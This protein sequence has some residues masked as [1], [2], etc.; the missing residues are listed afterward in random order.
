MPSSGN[1]DEQERVDYFGVNHDPLEV[2]DRINDVGDLASRPTLAAGG[3]ATILHG[4][5]QL[6]TPVRMLPVE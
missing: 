1:A 4:R 5:Y 2:E 6:W 3:L